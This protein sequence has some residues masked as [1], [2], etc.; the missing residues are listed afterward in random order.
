MEYGEDS[1]VTVR[2]GPGETVS[3]GAED[4]D[5]LLLEDLDSLPGTTTP[6]YFQ[7]GDAEGVLQ[8]VP[9]LDNS[10]PYLEPFEP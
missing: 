10:L 7:S 2:V 9:V 1:T 4:E 3:L 5:P 8:M 6:I